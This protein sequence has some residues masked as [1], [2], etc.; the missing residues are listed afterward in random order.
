MTVRTNGSIWTRD[1]P[2]RR[3]PVTSSLRV[4]QPP[5]QED[6]FAGKPVDHATAE[7]V[8]DDRPPVCPRC[9]KRL[10]I[11]ATHAAFD[12]L[13]RPTRRQL[14]GCPRGHATVYRTGGSFGSIE[15]LPDA[16]P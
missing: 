12:D 8:E 15:L 10:V 5:I 16:R 11:L 9:Q 13:G 3:D 4:D 7:P 14:W 2:E 6:V 1:D